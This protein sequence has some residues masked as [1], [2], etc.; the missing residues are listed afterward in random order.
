MA[1]KENFLTRKPVPRPEF[2]NRPDKKQD[3]GLKKAALDDVKSRLV[4]GTKLV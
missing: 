2:V 1:N 3:T 4:L